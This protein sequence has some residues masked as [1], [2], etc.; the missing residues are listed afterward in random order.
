MSGLLAGKVWQSNLS[1]HLKPLAAAMA[2]IANDDG[3]SIYPSVAYLAWLL[4]KGER[5]VQ[6]GLDE[7]K[8]LGVIEAVAYESGGRGKATEY[9][10]LEDRLPQRVPWK[11]FRKGATSAPFGTRKGATVGLQTVQ[12]TTERVQLE[13]QRV[14]P[15]APQPSVDPSL[16]PS[17]R[18][19]SSAVGC[20]LPEEFS[21]TTDMRQWASVETPN[22]NVDAAL[23]EFCDYWRA[24]PGK[25]GRKLDWIATW[26]NR[27]RVLQERAG[28]NGNGTYTQNNELRRPL[29][30]ERNNEQLKRNLARVEQLR[31]QG[32]GDSNEVESRNRSTTL[33]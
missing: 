3:T 19:T 28:R 8:G 11:E 1:S 29:A 32:G 16:Q 21:L 23:S 30:A 18:D 26:R 4:G 25:A 17:R 27:M 7:L 22:V 13:T 31:R 15:V 20:R 2:D 24:I 12:S 6:Y 10:L 14:Q 9:R 33:R 5:S